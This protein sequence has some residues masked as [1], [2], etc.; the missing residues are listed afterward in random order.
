MG[1]QICFYA[2]P[3]DL[4]DLLNIICT[5]NSIFDSSGTKLEFEEVFSRVNRDFSG[6]SYTASSLFIGQEEFRLS[7]YDGQTL[8]QTKSEI[9]QFNACSKNP[10]D[11]ID[12]SPVTSKF[13][14][15]GFIVIDDSDE[16]YRQMDELM[17]NPTF[18]SNPNYIE[19]GYGHGRFWYS[20]IYYDEIGQK[21]VKNRELDRLFNRICGY[22]R[23]NFKLTADKFAYIGPDAYNEY[24]QGSFIPCSGRNRII[25]E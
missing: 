7:Y 2:S 14:K 17:K 21:Q 3:D 19:N 16:Y 22:I 8:D 1:R 9:I 13:L 12:L 11:I 10:S 6:Q 20:P 23:K 24:I 25:V 18:I 5:N 15:N 4:Y